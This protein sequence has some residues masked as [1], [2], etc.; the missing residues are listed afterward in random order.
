M[1]KQSNHTEAGISHHKKLP[2]VMK[3]ADLPTEF[4]IG[5]YYNMYGQLSGGKFTLKSSSDE[6]QR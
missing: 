5:Y 4:D 6:Y 3:L 1:L 2:F